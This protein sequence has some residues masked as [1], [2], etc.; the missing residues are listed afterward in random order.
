MF[1]LLR[2]TLFLTA[3]AFITIV[4]LRLL[5]IRSVWL[6]STMWLVVL[7]QGVVVLPF[8]I[9]VRIPLPKATAGADKDLTTTTRDFEPLPDDSLTRSADLATNVS[10]PISHHRDW[11]RWARDIFLVVWLTGFLACVLSMVRRYIRFMKSLPP[12]VSC[13][14]AWQQ[15]WQRMQQE[16]GAHSVHLYVTSS[17]GPAL[18]LA[19]GG[20]QLLLPAEQW[21]L[22]SES[23]R[24]SVLRHE[25][26]HWRRG[27]VYRSVCFRVMAAMHW[28][29][30]LAWL[31]V[32][33]L[34]ECA[35]FACDDA[36]CR[37]R[38]D[39]P[40][41][42]LHALL[43]FSTDVT[44]VPITIPAASRH[45]LVGRV[46][47]LLSPEFME[48]ST[49]KRILLVCVLAVCAM[50]NLIN[51]RT[52]ADDD[53]RSRSLQVVPDPAVGGDAPSE[54]TGPADLSVRNDVA[55]SPVSFGDDVSPVAVLSVGGKEAVVDIAWLFAHDPQCSAGKE[56]VKELTRHAQL[57]LKE[58]NAKI[59][60]LA[61]QARNADAE[62]RAQLDTTLRTLHLALAQKRRA[63]EENLRNREVTLL[64]DSYQRIR[65]EIASYAQE[66][67]IT[68]VRRTM[69]QSDHA[70]LLESQNPQDV[71]KALNQDVIYVA[72]SCP[73][74]SQAI[75]DRLLKQQNVEAISQ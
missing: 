28:F 30:P 3:M 10:F 35:E 11:K 1:G 18:L 17:I 42:Y 65:R 36:V 8:T 33:R 74:I 41:D 71:I 47:R 15:Q 40:L 67:G 12:N 37:D 49:M 2:A 60:A 6:Q 22:L 58:A 52:V 72:D 34:E 43:E 7:L 21:D 45:S 39:L 63:T 9:E 38:D 64:R 25:L 19:P 23:Q 26:E 59:Q 56:E 68:L 31:A 4:L 13:P 32:R 75:L 5:K 70:R 61:A 46:R 48:E 51:V 57:E 50:A 53:V 69:R 27:D 62:E 54:A 55:V 44:V 20:H 66:H 16:F 73:D 24:Q 14:A 29:N